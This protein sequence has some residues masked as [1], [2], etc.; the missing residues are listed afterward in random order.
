MRVTLPLRRTPRTP[1]CPG[2]GVSGDRKRACFDRSCCWGGV[3]AEWRLLAVSLGWDPEGVD[4]GTHRRQMR[5]RGFERVQ[6]SVGGGRILE[7]LTGSGRPLSIERVQMACGSGAVG[8]REPCPFGSF[9]RVQLTSAFCSRVALGSSVRGG[10]HRQ[11]GR[12]LSS[13]SAFAASVN[14]S[15]LGHTVHHRRVPMPPLK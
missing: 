5:A 9:E 6:M 15:R 11:S 12:V 13:D 14:E 8:R 7:P 1:A 10:S 2:F 4:R 3:S